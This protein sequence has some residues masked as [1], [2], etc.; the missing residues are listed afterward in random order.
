MVATNPMKDVAE[1]VKSLPTGSLG[2][3]AAA[4]LTPV[5]IPLFS[6]AAARRAKRCEGFDIVE[7]TIILSIL[8][9]FIMLMGI[10]SV[11][12]AIIAALVLLHVLHASGDDKY[13][14]VSILGLSLPLGIFL[15]YAASTAQFSSFRFDR[16]HVTYR[17]FGR[18]QTFDWAGVRVFR[19]DSIW[20]PLLILTSGRRIRVCEYHRGFRDLL[21]ATR[22]HGCLDESSFARSDR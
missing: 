4:I 14:A 21:E 1:F 6:F 19:R 15:F 10:G 16:D 11:L 17:Y 8:N 9:Y 5:L 18:E 20:G 2:P 7:P 12:F 13:L 3:I 22:D